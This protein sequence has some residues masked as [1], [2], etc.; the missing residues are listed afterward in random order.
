VDF[1]ILVG[2]LEL[3]AQQ[4]RETI[5]VSQHRLME[6]ETFLKLGR[7]FM[8]LTEADATPAELMSVMTGITQRDRV[9]EAAERLLADGQRRTTRDLLAEMNTFGVQ[10]GG[11]DPASTLSTYLS[12]DK[13]FSND[14]RRGG[15]TL[16]SLE[17]QDGERQRHLNALA[18]L[19]QR[20]PTQEYGLEDADSPLARVLTR[21]HRQS[22]D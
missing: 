4:L 17:S 1:Q 20:N 22:K 8:G 13:R 18:N 7:R 6:I 5:A 12:R 11:V 9:L 19:M 15:W 16:A 2:R 21:H 10:P 3:E 14:N